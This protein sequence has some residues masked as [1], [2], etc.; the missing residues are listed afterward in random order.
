MK[1]GYAAL[2]GDLNSSRAASSGEFKFN[3][4]IL[5]LTVLNNIDFTI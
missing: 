1:R 5:I 4:R 3:I 2:F